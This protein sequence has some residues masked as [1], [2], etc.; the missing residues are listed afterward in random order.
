MATDRRK[1]NKSIF[2]KKTTTIN[3]DYDKKYT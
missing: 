1:K 3:A 2:K